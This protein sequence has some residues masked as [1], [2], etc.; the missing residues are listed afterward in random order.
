MEFIRK[1]TR[2]REFMIFVIV[3]GV[4]VIMSFASP[5][6]L[7]SANIL[8]L[9]LGLS[10]ETIIAVGMT[11]LMVSGGFDMSVGSIVA[12][13]GAATAM[14]MKLGIPVIIAVLIGLAIGAGIGLF[15]G[16]IIAKVG[17][18]PFV[19]TLASMSLFRGLTLIVTKGQNIADLPSSFKVIGQKVFLGVQMPI[20]YAIILVIVGDILLRK[21][22]FFR[23]NYYIGG[24]EKAAY[25]SGIAVDKIKILNYVITAL[26]AAFAGIVMTSRL[27][28]A[29]VT[30]GQGLELKVITAVIIGGASL[31]GGEG[32]VV[33]AFMGS[34]LMA[35]I[36]NA[37]TLLG[38]DV[39]W[40]TFV[41]G[42]T[43]LIAVLI[44]RIGKI[45]KERKEI[46]TKRGRAK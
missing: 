14:C 24:N 27:G 39:Y 9:L 4:V 15:N 6:F 13:T 31:Q 42:A 40:Q 10:I 19:T 2:L 21:A 43:L 20:W 33:G 22:R 12:F 30:A 36:T 1:I 7:N 38:I 29:S 45:R 11:N 5:Y 41:I 3:L 16:V 17:I 18:N 35:L 37:L 44:D 25:L 8:A 46:K 26:L 23:Q 28:A 32:T 34:V